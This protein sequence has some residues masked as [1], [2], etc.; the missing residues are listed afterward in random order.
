[1]SNPIACRSPLKGRWVR[2]G[3]RPARTHPLADCGTEQ[4][5]GSLSVV[6]ARI[7]YHLSLTKPASP[8]HE[9]ESRLEA[10]MSSTEGGLATKRRQH[11]KE[12]GLE[13]FTAGLFK[14]R[15]DLAL[16]SPCSSRLGRRRHPP[17][18]SSPLSRPLPRGFRGL[19]PQGLR[20]V[21]A[22]ES[23]VP[24]VTQRPLHLLF[25]L[26]I[27]RRVIPVPPRVDGTILMLHDLPANGLFSKLCA[28]SVCF[29]DFSQ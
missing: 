5:N 4:V 20:L 3:G 25:G 2:V 14:S 12:L 6:E 11:G 17:D 26:H 22:F 9:G 19:F 16:A 23:T 7:A 29:A 27:S 18:L 8:V 21:I 1:V 10:S 15:L 28:H 24:L 13:E